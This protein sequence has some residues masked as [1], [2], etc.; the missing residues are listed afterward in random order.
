M[1]GSDRA[2][3]EISGSVRTSGAP[4][5]GNSAAGDI[6]PDSGAGFSAGFAALVVGALLDFIFGSAFAFAEVSAFGFEA[7][8]GLGFGFAFDLDF[9]FDAVLFFGL[10]AF[11][12]GL[13]ADFMVVASDGSAFGSPDPVRAL[14]VLVSAPFAL[15]RIPAFLFRARAAGGCFDFD[16]AITSKSLDFADYSHIKQEV[17]YVFLLRGQYRY[18]KSCESGEF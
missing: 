1:P 6:V 9:G 15:E 3:R 14:T 7:A 18:E 17:V 13:S 16:R 12:P 11:V 10:F 4:A 2:S 8:F 5:A